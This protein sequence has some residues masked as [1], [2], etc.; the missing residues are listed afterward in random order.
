MVR[1]LLLIYAVVEFA[2][3]VGLAAAIG[4]GWT[5]LVLAATSGL[6]LV[7]WAP[8]G[9]YQLSRK[10]LELRSGETKPGKALSDSALV[11]V[12]TGLV[13]VPGLASTVLGLLLLVPPIRAV[14]RPALTAIAMRGF[15]RH[16]PLTAE[17]A[18]AARAGLADARYVRR[19]PDNQDFIDGEVISVEDVY[20]VEP[21]P[22]PYTRPQTAPGSTQFDRWPT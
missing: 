1:R 5:L 16:A 10:L 18:Y 3:F 19:T 13:L 15:L 11:A 17:E 12:A 2:V 22:L 4:L 8:L 6:G 20:H 7:L 21:P 9:G 14:A